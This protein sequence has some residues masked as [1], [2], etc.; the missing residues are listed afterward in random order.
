MTRSELTNKLLKENPELA[1]ADVEN[2]IETFFSQ[3][4][5]TL[6][7]GRTGG[8][9]RVWHCFPL[10]NAINARGAIPAPANM[11]RLRRKTCRFS[12]SVASCTH[13]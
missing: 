6:E 8:I 9:A 7:K 5:A 1:L 13:G 3:I 11:L 10:K 4:V 2:I 12:K